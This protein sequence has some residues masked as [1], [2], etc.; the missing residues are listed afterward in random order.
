VP[1]G[2]RGKGLARV[3]SWARGVGEGGEE[4]GL[5]PGPNREEKEGGKREW[6]VSRLRVCS[7]EREK[8]RERGQG[9]MREG[10]CKRLACP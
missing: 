6:E 8:R 10:S 7:L 2:G 1:V 9:P 3:L 5:V 4:R